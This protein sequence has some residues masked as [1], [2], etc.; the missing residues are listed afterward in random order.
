MKY[1]N[2]L[3]NYG[4]KP[5]KHHVIMFTANRIIH[6]SGALIMGGGNALACAMALPTTPKLFGRKLTAKVRDLA[7][8][9][10]FHPHPLEVEA[11]IGAMFTKNHYKDPSDLDTV[12]KAIENLK[13]IANADT[14][15]TFHLPYPAIGLGGLSRTDLDEHVE[16]LPDNVLVYV[17][18][19][20]P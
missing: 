14:H 9:N 6:P 16:K 8:H 13:E 11:G 20:H 1:I 5:D 15:L 4:V 7:V 18:Y 19:P 10:L 2:A 12:I 3:I 17:V